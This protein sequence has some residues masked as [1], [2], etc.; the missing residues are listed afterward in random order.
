VTAAC[1]RQD[2]VDAE[3]A[4]EELF[5]ILLLPSFKPWKKM[6][7]FQMNNT[8]QINNWHSRLAM[9]RRHH[10]SLLHPHHGTAFE[11]PNQESSSEVVPHQQHQSGTT[12]RG[13]DVDVAG[14]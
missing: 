12:T 8:H 5:A 1:S 7:S 14:H 4:A 3:D 10:A 11:D 2:E 13:P 9:N 6:C